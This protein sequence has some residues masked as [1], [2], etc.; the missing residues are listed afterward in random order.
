MGWERW[1][2]SGRMGAVGWERWGQWYGNG[3]R[4]FNLDVFAWLTGDVE[5]IIPE[6]S[7]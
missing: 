1:D 7:L 3:D 2:G 5:C 4:R 6:P